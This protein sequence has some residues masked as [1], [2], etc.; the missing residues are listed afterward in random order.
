MDRRANVGWHGDQGDKGGSHAHSH[1]FKRAKAPNTSKLRIHQRHQMIEAAKCLVVGIPA[2]PPLHGSFE[3][4]P[5]YRLEKPS[6]NAI[7]VS[8][9]R[10]FFLSLDNQKVAAS[11]ETIVQIVP[12]HRPISAAY[13]QLS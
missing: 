8:H 7:A 13:M 5:R 10:P 3:S 4:P 6:K 12:L 2:M 11:R 9:A 1:R